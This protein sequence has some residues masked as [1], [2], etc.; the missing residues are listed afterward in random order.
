MQDNDF[1]RQV[2]DR[3]FVK[4]IKELHRKEWSNKLKAREQEC[5]REVMQIRLIMALLLF[6]VVVFL[7]F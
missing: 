5:K 2:E 1:E 6:A 4:D 3:R 7:L